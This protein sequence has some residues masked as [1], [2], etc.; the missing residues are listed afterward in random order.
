MVAPSDGDIGETW[1][2]RMEVMGWGWW[3]NPDSARR[4]V[5]GVANERVHER[6]EIKR[7]RLE[8]AAG[9][10]GRKERREMGQ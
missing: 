7:A 10:H 3:A 9:W 4:K 6:P 5:H 2:L 1:L 8:L